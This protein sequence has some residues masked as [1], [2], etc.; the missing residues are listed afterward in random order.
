[1]LLALVWLFVLS[2][3]AACIGSTAD[4]NTPI[5]SESNSSLSH[6]M[7]MKKKEDIS[8]IQDSLTIMETP[9]ETM[10]KTY[11]VHHEKDGTSYTVVLTWDAVPFNIAYP[12]LVGDP[13][14]KGDEVYNRNFEILLF[15]TKNHVLQTIPLGNDIFGELDFQDVN[16]DGYIDIV[17]T[18]VLMAQK[19]PDLPVHE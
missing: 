2:S 8:N 4:Q 9:I 5:D 18:P 7:D 17:F 14:F 19:P 16:F 11:A 6:E 1:M 13:F 12:E 3:L 10:S 15:D